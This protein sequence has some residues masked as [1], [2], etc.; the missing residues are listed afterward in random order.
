MLF[1]INPI[2]RSRMKNIRSISFAALSVMLLLSQI[3]INAIPTVNFARFVPTKQTLVKVAK[4]AV[5][6]VAAAAVVAY[7]Y[8]TGHL[9]TGLEYVKA[10]FNAGLNTV[11]GADYKTLGTNAAASVTNGGAFK[12]MADLANV[13]KEYKPELVVAGLTAGTIYGAKQLKLNTVKKE[14]AQ[15]ADF[16]KKNGLTPKVAPVAAPKAK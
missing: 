16:N 12:G 13:A 2:W 4:Y 14:T 11:K 1:I 10:G 9:N 3:Q 8:K 6:P 7:A 5:A 15:R